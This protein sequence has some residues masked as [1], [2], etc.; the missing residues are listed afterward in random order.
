MPVASIYVK[1]LFGKVSTEPGSDKS[2]SVERSFFSFFFQRSKLYVYKRPMWVQW[3][4]GTRSAR[5]FPFFFFLFLPTEPRSDPTF[6]LPVLLDQLPRDRKIVFQAG[7]RFRRS[8]FWF[9]MLLGPVIGR[10]RLSKTSGNG[11]GPYEATGFLLISPIFLSILISFFFLPS[12][13]ST[14]KHLLNERS[15]LLS[16]FVSDDFHNYRSKNPACEVD[17]SS[18]NIC[19]NAG[20]GN[21]AIFLHYSVESVWFIVRPFWW[22]T[23]PVFWFRG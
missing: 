19:S 21:N 1:G 13:S 17:V 5:I 15:A 20:S 11:P 8:G 18:R 7:N 4:I 10:L 6:S 3:P 23:G 12:W 9:S 22:D 14:R 2:S 16:F